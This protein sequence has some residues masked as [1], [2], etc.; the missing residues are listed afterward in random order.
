[1]GAPIEDH[2]AAIAELARKH[3]ELVD[4]HAAMNLRLDDQAEELREN[5]KAT[6]EN[7]A[8][9]AVVGATAE[10]VE[11]NTK[12]IVEAFVAAQGAFKTLGVLT[13]FGKRVA[14]IV[15]VPSAI[16]G[17]IKAALAWWRG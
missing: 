9:L 13:D 6:Q 7:A 15:L 8:A 17:G 3:A 14:W 4:G 16:A 10:R 12:Q 1:M 11:S 2:A 5:T